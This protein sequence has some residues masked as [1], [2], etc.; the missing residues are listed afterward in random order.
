MLDRQTIRSE[1]VSLFTNKTSE[2]VVLHLWV[3]ATFAKSGKVVEATPVYVHTNPGRCTPAKGTP[4]PAGMIVPIV[5]MP[6]QS[7]YGVTQENALVG[8]SVVD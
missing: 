7:L 2:S 1:K 6:R 4:I 5:L 8:F 3:L